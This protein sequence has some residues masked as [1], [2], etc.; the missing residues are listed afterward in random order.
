M[1]KAGPAETTSSKIAPSIRSY[2][3][4]TVAEEILGV[5]ERTVDRMLKGGVLKGYR[6]R[7]Q[8][9]V[10]HKSLEALIR[11]NEITSQTNSPLVEDNV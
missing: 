4:K 1:A 2:S 10:T 8:I 7:R 11:D 9:R 6:V 5:S 3:K